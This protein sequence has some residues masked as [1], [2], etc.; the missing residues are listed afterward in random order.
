M[1]QFLSDL[2]I[3][4][5]ESCENIWML[6]EPLIYESDQL[7]IIIVPKGFMTDL[8]ST[9]HIP[10]VSMIWGDTAHREAV[11][12]DYLYCIDSEPVVGFSTANSVFIEAMK[13][14]DKGIFVRY[15]M[16]WGVWIGGY[17]HYHVHKV[18][19]N[20]EDNQCQPQGPIQT[21]QP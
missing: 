8:A 16:F 18:D 6:D 4:C 21:I 10:F 14:R 2:I 1:S 7:G 11:V 19:W 15:P 9:R 13:A 20:P 5:S 3:R 12:H 17:P